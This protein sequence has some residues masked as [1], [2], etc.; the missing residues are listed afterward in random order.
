MLKIKV[1]GSKK[2]L[3]DHR[4]PIQLVSYSKEPFPINLEDLGRGSQTWV[5]I[6]CTLRFQGSCGLEFLIPL[7]MICKHTLY[8]NGVQWRW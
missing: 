8:C 1:L 6:S 5:N 3:V 2:S 4:V 7:Y